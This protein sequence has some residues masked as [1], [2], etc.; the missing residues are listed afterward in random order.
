MIKIIGAVLIVGA[1]T[2]F[3]LSA[4]FGL[5]TRAR[6]LN[7]FSRALRIMYSEISERLTPLNELMQRLVVLSDDP[8]N[9]FFK[10]CAE[11]ISAKPDIPFSIIWKKLILRSEYLKLNSRE[12]EILSALG[13]VLGRYSADEQAKAIEHTARCVETMAIDAERERVR[14]GGL[15]AKLGAIC[16]IAFVIVFI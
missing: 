11:E 4:A 8:L 3:G 16:G 14:L 6:T 2:M 7:A 15:Y 12:K 1:A 13:A 5:H 10:Q 9:S